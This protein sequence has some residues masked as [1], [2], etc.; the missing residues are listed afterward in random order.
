MSADVIQ[1]WTSFAAGVNALAAITLLVLYARSRPARWFSCFSL[2]LAGV[3]LAWGTGGSAGVQLNHVVPAAF[4]GF[5]LSVQPKWPPWCALAGFVITMVV[6][7][8]VHGTSVENVVTICAWFCGAMLLMRSTIPPEVVGRTDTT[9]RAVFGTLVAMPLV[10]L[11]GL[12]LLDEDFILLAVPM[13][14]LMQGLGLYGAVRFRMYEVSKRHERSGRLAAHAVEDD[15]SRVVGE[16]GAMLAHEI[17]NP[18]TGI[19]SLTEQ[20]GDPDVDDAT[21][22][23]YA[24]LILKEV[25]RLETLVKQVL[26][27]S[28]R[29]AAPATGQPESDLSSLFSDLDALLSPSAEEHRVRLA[30]LA[31][32]PRAATSSPALGQALLNLVTN[33]ITHS[34]EGSD[35]TVTAHRSGQAVEISVRDHGPGIPAG[36]NEQVFQPFFS[37]SGGTGLGLAIVRSLA[38]EHGWEVSGTNLESGG[39]EFLIRIPDAATPSAPATRRLVTTP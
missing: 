25:D 8:G 29:P 7:E 10:T 11:A 27:R 16:V 28:K 23:S 18:L 13:T 34:P 14:V 24:D 22:R 35:V 39:A 36:L 1:L 37:Q 32:T 2:A 21:R 9:R 4:V 3:F 31:E 17:R 30:W 6:L 19:R 26:E 33:A 20:L 15:R 12:L 38:E 5:A